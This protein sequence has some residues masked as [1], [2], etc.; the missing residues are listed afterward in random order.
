MVYNRRILPIYTNDKGMLELYQSM[1]D[2]GML[3]LKST[4]A[5][6]LSGLGTFSAGT[7]LGWAKPSVE[8]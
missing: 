4:I 2:K 7:C 6:I 1:I 8:N 3:E 5:C